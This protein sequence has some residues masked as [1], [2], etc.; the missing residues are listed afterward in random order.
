M[1]KLVTGILGCLM[2]LFATGLNAQEPEAAPEVKPVG[3][4]VQFKYDL[5]KLKE[6]ADKDAKSKIEAA[7]ES[8]E[9]AEAGSAQVYGQVVRIFDDGTTSETN[10]FFTISSD[11]EK[12]TNVSYRE[13]DDYFTT[14]NVFM[15]FCAVLVFIMHLGFA[16][17][18]TGLTRAKNTVNILFKNVSIVAIAT[19]VYAII[20]FNL[21]YPCGAWIAD[22]WFPQFVP[23]LAP[24]GQMGADYAG[25]G[26]TYWTD[27][28]F[29]AMF[30]AATA[31]VVSGAVCE[32]IKLSAFLIFCTV[33]AGLVYP[34]LG[35]AK[36]GGGFLADMGFAD[37]AGSTLVHSVGGWGALAGAIVLGPRIG[38]YVNGKSMAIMGHNMPLATI[39]CMLLWFGWFGFNAGSQ[40]NADPEKTSQIMVSTL[41]SSCA[42]VI[43]AMITSW[44]VQKKPDL[45]M[46]LN[47]ALAGL[48]G[49][50]AGAD[51]IAGFGAV[52]VGLIAGIVVVFAVLLVDS[53]KIDDPVGAVSVHLVC[54][55]WGTLA[56]GLFGTASFG[57]QVIGV[58]YY[59]IAFPSA[60]LIFF[61]L[62]MTIGIR[63]DEEEEIGGLDVGEHGMEAYSGFQIFSNQ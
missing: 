37:L 60:F 34:I 41:L 24:D 17:L 15:M 55:I 38:K 2:L 20:G 29:Q 10:A 45:S 32:R 1:K 31:S 54:G 36:W 42:G 21:M 47:G 44:I 9:E 18:E 61:I 16:T 49:I 48:V 50:T 7:K 28:L 39:G 23:G 27:F 33:F 6:D 22:G 63:V 13:V 51:D 8:G 56:C 52:W 25:A 11:G 30:A 19:I 46:I 3:V 35:A 58:L 5:K 40:L 57:T 53:V 59:A 62:K 14:S 4:K 43:G 26:Y 12:F